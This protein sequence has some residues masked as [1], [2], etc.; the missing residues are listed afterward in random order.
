M[1]DDF[2]VNWGFGLRGMLA[3]EVELQFPGNLHRWPLL[4]SFH[5]EPY[6]AGPDVQL[7]VLRDRVPANPIPTIDGLK[8]WPDG[9]PRFNFPS[10]PEQL[11]PLLARI[12]ENL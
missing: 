7:I 3:Q 10:Q 12:R 5:V 6:D 2:G 9:M 11:Q 8:A 4:N 1:A